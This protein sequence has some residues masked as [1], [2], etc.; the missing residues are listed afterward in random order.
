MFAAPPNSCNSLNFAAIKQLF[1]KTFPFL[2]TVVPN[3][4][5]RAAESVLGRVHPSKLVVMFPAHFMG[6]IIGC[7]VLRL[8]IPILPHEVFM[9]EIY[10][11]AAWIEAFVREVLVNFLFVSFYLVVPEMLEVNGFTRKWMTLF[12]LPFAF[13]GVSDKGS[14]FSPAI[15]YALWYVTHESSKLS[16]QMQTEH[17]AGPLVGALLAGLLCAKFFPDDPFWRRK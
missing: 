1:L 10:S 4:N 6:A 9:P 2:D 5:I 7:T 8:I 13:I 14:T 16:V 17:L 3:L 15:N 12:T 11:E